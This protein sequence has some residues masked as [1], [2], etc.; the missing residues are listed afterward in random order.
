MKLSKN[1]ETILDQLHE[2]SINI[3]KYHTLYK[4]SQFA[5]EGGSFHDFIQICW[6]IWSHDI[7]CYNHQEI[8][9]FGCAARS[10]RP[11]SHQADLH[12]LVG[13]WP[14]PL[15]NMKVTWDD[16]IPNIWKN[17]KSL[18]PPTRKACCQRWNHQLL[19]NYLYI[20]VAFLSI[21]YMIWCFFAVH[22]QTFSSRN[23]DRLVVGAEK[24]ICFP[25]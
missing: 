8:S 4:H 14:T 18:K 10:P 7:L 23:T 2:I 15:K 11:S 13:G 5:I 25:K 6:L 22:A 19:I 1:I 20:F 24:A 3:N 21:Y 12:S 9:K 16:D 17:K